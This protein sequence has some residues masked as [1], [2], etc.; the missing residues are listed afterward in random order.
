MAD[1]TGPNRYLP[2]HKSIP[3]EGMMCDGYNCECSNPAVV[4]VQG[5]TDSW[6]SEISDY[7]QKCY[8]LMHVDEEAPTPVKC[9]W[10]GTKALCHPTRD[11]EEGMCGRV[12]DVCVPCRKKQNDVAINE[13]SHD[14]SCSY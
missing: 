6:G 9:E 10:C 8:D 5:E 13:L 3:P 14:D 7:C 2:G 12:Y 4:R 1:V 11:Y